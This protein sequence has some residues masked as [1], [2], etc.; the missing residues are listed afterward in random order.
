VGGV[1]WALLARGTRPREA[2]GLLLGI[3]LLL[4]GLDLMKSG[5]E[6]WA[7]AFDGAPFAG[8]PLLLVALVGMVA[9]AVI[10]SSTAAMM[11]VLGALHGGLIDLPSAAA[12]AAGTGIGTTFTALLGAL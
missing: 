2:T 11:I 5:V 8:W 9:T 6:E 12:F 4:Y 7:T 3:G 10:Q 1:G